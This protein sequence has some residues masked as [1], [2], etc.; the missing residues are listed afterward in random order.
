LVA[1]RATVPVTQMPPNN[2]ETILP[3]PLRTKFAIRPV[4]AAGHSV[5]D[6]GR[7]KRFNS[8]EQSDRDGVGQHSLNF[9]EAERW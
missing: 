3:Q 6:D 9:F 1:V 8:S 2:T 7:Q 5:G 4:A